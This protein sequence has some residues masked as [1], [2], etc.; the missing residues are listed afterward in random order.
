M[1]DGVNIATDEATFFVVHSSAY[2]HPSHTPA[3]SQVELPPGTWQLRPVS[4]WDMS[5]LAPT[6]TLQGG[7]KVTLTGAMLTF[8]GLTNNDTLAPCGRSS[9]SCC[10]EDARACTPYS[11][12]LTLA[13]N[14]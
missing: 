8:S 6:V 14:H 10:D 9:A 12:I 3:D 2:N 11:A 1:G 7:A 4:F 13:T 5:I